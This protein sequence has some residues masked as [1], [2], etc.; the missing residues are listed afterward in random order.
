VLCCVEEKGFRMK[1]GL[2]ED[3]PAILDYMTTALQMAGYS[4][5]AHTTSASLLDSLLTGEGLAN[6]LPYDV[7]I[8]DLLLPGNIPG[9]AAIEHIHQLISPK[10]LPIII[11]SACSQ[12]ELEQVKEKL[13]YV[14]VLRKPF[15]MNAL[16]QLIEKMNPS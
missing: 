4:V 10:R 7:V 15:K 1:I 13:P 11:I 12:T 8:I 9:L 6:P 2:L 14:P 3:N 5:E 16:L